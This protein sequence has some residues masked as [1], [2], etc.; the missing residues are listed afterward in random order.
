M[1]T[2]PREHN[3]VCFKILS[4]QLKSL[5]I[6]TAYASLT[7][8]LHFPEIIEIM[9]KAAKTYRVAVLGAG[10]GAAVHLPAFQ[11]DKRCHVQ[12]L[13][14]RNKDKGKAICQQLGVEAFYSDWQALLDNESINICAIAL[15]PKL[16]EAI[17]PELCERGIHFLCEK[18]LASSLEQAQHCL[19]HVEKYGVIGAIDYVFPEIP[20]WR[21][22][23]DIVEQQRLGRLHSVSLTWT[24]QTYA[25]KLG[26]HAWKLHRERGGGVMLSFL[27]HSLYYL[28]WLLGPLH[29]CR[30][31]VFEIRPG[32][33]RRIE[34][35]FVVGATKIPGSAIVAIDAVGQPEHRLDIYGADGSLVLENLTADYI[36]GF[37]GKLY[38]D[39]T[40]QSQ[41]LPGG[42]EI[43]GKDGR[44]YAVSRIV[45]RL[46]DS[47][48]TGTPLEPHV[49][50]GFRVQTLLNEIMNNATYQSLRK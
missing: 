21:N 45:R 41:L 35:Q 48:E 23:K 31:Q 20:V 47:I 9:T 14:C 43:G 4:W 11:N 26:H 38:K 42:A 29:D 22:A 40:D 46:I 36:A 49:S 44:L 16:Q 32:E 8:G 34:L 24:V 2:K 50:A 6:F 1:G 30:A 37:T 12:A 13:C 10:F 27:S 5:T 18:P 17:I 3:Q 33:D 25:A 28:E 15:P 39:G 7:E 19:S